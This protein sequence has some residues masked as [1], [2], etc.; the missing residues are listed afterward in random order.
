MYA[1]MVFEFQNNEHK[2]ITV[3]QPRSG[4][5]L[6]PVVIWAKKIH[7]V[8][9]YE[10]TTKSKSVNAL[11][12]RKTRHYIK[13]KEMF[14]HITNTVNNTAGLGYT[15]DDVGNYSI[16]SSLA[17]ALYLSK[18]VVSTITLIIRWS[19]DAFLLYIRKQVQEFS[20]G[21][22]ADMVAIDNFFTIPDLQEHDSL[23]PL[24]RNFRSL[25]N[26][27]LR[28]NTLHD[29]DHFIDSNNIQKT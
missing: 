20:A 22:S 27:I 24:T 4:K 26:T 14:L 11:V 17:M 1:D 28:N 2:H 19:S 6:C 5:E 12:I 10:G 21:I 13:A 16:R 18:R 3:A 9:S 23:G 8:L 7:R 15:G 25:A 29:C